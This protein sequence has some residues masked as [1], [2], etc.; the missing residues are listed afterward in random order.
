MDPETQAAAILVVDDDPTVPAALKRAMR[1]SG[2]EVLAAGSGAEALALLA[3]RSASVG[4]VVSDYAM[5]GV[6]GADLLRAIRVR[7]P[8]IIRVL[9]TGGAD[10][11]AASRTV[12]EAQVWRL[13]IKPW[14]ARE[15]RE[16]LLEALDE[17]QQE[18][19]QRRRFG[20]AA[21]REQARRERER[22][23]EELTQALA[24]NVHESR[25][26]QMI[27]SDAARLLGGAHSRIWLLD[28]EMEGLTCAAAEGPSRAEAVGARLPLDSVAGQVATAGAVL[29]LEDG[30]THPAW[31]ADP[32]LVDR[33]NLGA[34]LGAPVFRA[35]VALGTIEVVR[36]VGHPF[37]PDDQRLLVQLANAAAV[38]IAAGRLW[39]QVHSEADD[40]RQRLYPE[41]AKPSP[42]DT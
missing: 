29:T 33:P 1:P 8:G 26:L 4:V 17:Y 13:L 25:T 22:A 38:A 14:Q 37:T 42:N 15:I 10:L 12:N 34:Y 18:R 28:P 2:V 24:D 3:E 27:A 9:L 35:H 30:R 20:E 39:R 6:N 11:A 7:W 31:R 21:M 19:E 32:R 16:T 36:E 40:A 5:P 23:L 41:L